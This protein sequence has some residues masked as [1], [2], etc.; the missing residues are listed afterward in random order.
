M[1]TANHSAFDAS[2]LFNLAITWGTAGN[3]NGKEEYI[4][5]AVP[6]TATSAPGWYVKKINYD[7]SGRIILIQIAMGADGH[8]TFSNIFDNASTLYYG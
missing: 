4:G 7:A 3:A 2:A 5:H 8:P 1:L 6:G